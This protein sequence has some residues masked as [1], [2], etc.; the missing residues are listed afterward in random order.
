MNSEFLVTYRDIV[1]KPDQITK[2]TA[3]SLKD[4]IQQVQDYPECKYV[5]KVYEIVWDGG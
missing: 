5:L 4:A 3:P 2:V 1:L